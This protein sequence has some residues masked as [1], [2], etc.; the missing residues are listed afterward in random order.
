MKRR[1]LV[2]LSVDHPKLVMLAVA[3]LTLVAIIPLPRIRTDTNPKNMLPP[4]SDVRVG[5]SEVEK[6]FRL[7]EDMIVVGIENDGG[8]LQLATL[9]KVA[10]V[11]RAIQ[12]VPG[13]AAADVTSFLTATNVTS[14]AGT[15]NVGPVMT[16]PPRTPAEVEAMRRALFGNPLLIDRIVSQDEK[17]TAIYVPLEKGANGK[18][19]ADAIRALL[20]KEHGAERYYVAGDPVARDTFG[21]EMFRLMGLFSPIAGLVMVLVLF[22]MFRSFLPAVT[23]MAVAMIAILWSFGVLVALGFPV[24]IMSSM[25]PVFL[26]AIATDSIH[27]FNEYAFRRGETRDRRT[28]ILATMDAVSRPVRYTALATA[29]GFGVLLI[30]GI[31]P[32]RV[33]G[34][35]VAFGTVMLRVLSFSFIPA[36]LSLAKEPSQTPAHEAE[37]KARTHDP[38]ILREIAALGARR[39]VPVLTVSLILVVLAI[40]GTARIVVNNNMVEW[41]RPSSEVRRADEALNRQLG[42]TSTGY[43]VASS[44]TPDFFK[45]PE[46]LRALENLQ[47]RLKRHEVVGTTLSVADYVKRIH[48]VLH[49][50]D[51]KYL[52][53]PDDAE[54]IGQYLFLFGMA[55]RPLDLDNVVDYQFQN[56]NIQIQLRTWDA[57]AM[58][59]VLRELEDFRAHAPADMSVRPAGIAYF[60]LV[61]NDE[62][63]WDMVRGF[64]LALVVVFVILAANFRS[65]RWALIGYVPLLFTVLLI[66]GAVGWLGKDFD[67]PIAVLSCLSLGMAVDFSI[68]FIGRLRQFLV[69]EDLDGKSPDTS[70]LNHALLWTASRP[71]RGILRNAVLFAAAF[72]VMLFAPLTPYMT[73]GAFIMTMMLLSALF[74]LLL[75]PALIT[76]SRRWLFGDRR[77]ARAKEHAAKAGI[78]LEEIPMSRIDVRAVVLA[79]IL[80]LAAPVAVRAQMPA[81]EVAKKSLDAFYA[82]GKDMQTRVSMTLVNAQGGERKRELTLLRKNMP[83][84]TEQR[85][86]MYFHNPPDVKGTTFLVWKYLGKD[87]DRWIYIPAIKLVRRIA[88]SDKRSSFVGSDFTYEDVSGRDV[89]DETHTVL[90]EENLGDRP[91]YVLESKPV[92]SADY[93]KRVSWIDKERWLPLKEDYSDSR[94]RAIR[95]F[96]A[97]KVEQIGGH[98]TVTQ[99]TMKNLTAGQHTVVVFQN[100]V[101]DQGLSDNLFTER[102][103]R[104]PPASVR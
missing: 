1:S 93:A 66:Y 58:R 95:A 46:A 62:V 32:V 18:A 52:A 13:V 69:E 59:E 41:F 6:T 81:A 94:G 33:F 29:A 35:L 104:E 100:V 89:S 3:I 77:P 68:H 34:G 87:D 76:L 48:Y 31:I 21:V 26:M 53:I 27:I 64:L 75:L 70:E 97:D 72:S 85:Y 11:T 49:D 30:M 44:K 22:V 10:R 65:V 51:P 83:A 60:N 43:V 14:G 99:R 92:A 54:T 80:A 78:E 23:T 2:T 79:A 40:A 55:A 61:W 47:A 74:T 102:S 82:Q 4:T 25:S 15:L 98:W 90:R 96:T 39:P 17:T 45:R 19:V 91:C 86:Y 84:A 88:A 7:Y 57:N 20:S 50:E 5:N 16:E 9:E 67:M 36:V 28:A 63:L 37:E 71:G 73:V 101:Y 24:H 12:E 8:V 56:A 42:G 103:L 38:G